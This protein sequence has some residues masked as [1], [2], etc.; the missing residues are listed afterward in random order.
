MSRFHKRIGVSVF[1]CLFLVVYTLMWV[2][3]LKPEKKTTVLSST[4]QSDLFSIQKLIPTV[5]PTPTPVGLVLPD[6]YVIPVTPRKQFFKLSC[7]F[8]A[9]STIISHY[10]NKSS[11]TVASEEDAEK[12]LMAQVGISQNPNIGIR[13]GSATNSGILYSNLNE[14]FGGSDF[15]GVHAPPFVDV[16]ATYGLK[17]VSI[18]RDGEI[19]NRIKQTL[20]QGHLIMAW[21]QDQRYFGAAEVRVSYGAIVPVVYGE[22]AIVIHGY[23]GQYVVV[24]DP[25]VGATRKILFST[26]VAATG[27]FLVPLLEVYPSDEILGYATGPTFPIDVA[28]GIDRTQ[29]TIAILDGAD[30]FSS[31]NELTEVLH[32]FGYRVS[33]RGKA[34]TSTYSHVTLAIKESKSDYLY[35]LKKD[36]QLSQYTV[37]TASATL[38]EQAPTDV[39]LTIGH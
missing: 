10:T 18:Y 22:H 8:A 29:L 4:S 17:A 30:N 27:E 9:A 31:V 36:L 32:Q 15:Y 13:M 14:K 21:V 25:A 5:T 24:M 19:V 16:F 23:D 3:I 2:Q 34:D 20:V 26:L 28:T 12:T 33:V 38:P 11:F 39:V 6:S 35:L 1:C 37:G 7:E